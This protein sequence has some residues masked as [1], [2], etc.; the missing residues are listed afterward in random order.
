MTPDKTNFTLGNAYSQ[1][2]TDTAGES[3]VRVKAMTGD[4]TL[5]KELTVWVVENH[6]PNS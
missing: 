5:E 6:K 4:K 2:R 3:W 1:L